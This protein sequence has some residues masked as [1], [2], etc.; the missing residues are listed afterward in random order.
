MSDWE[1]RRS[2]LAWHGRAWQGKCT[3]SPR[4]GRLLAWIDRI[5]Q[6]CCG[7]LLLGSL[8]TML[9]DSEFTHS[10]K[11]PPL[12]SSCLLLLPIASPYLLSLPRFK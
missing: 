1:S 2:L 12:A 6:Q 9:N 3:T 8:Q 7:P 4:F 10:D 11:M 5:M